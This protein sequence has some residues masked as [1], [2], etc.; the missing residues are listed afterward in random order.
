MNTTKHAVSDYLD[1]LFL[2]VSLK[3]AIETDV[4]SG[5]RIDDAGLYEAKDSVPLGQ[6]VVP[7]MDPFQLTS[8]DYQHASQTYVAYL[9]LIGICRA[10][11][12]GSLQRYCLQQCD[13]L[14]R[15]SLKP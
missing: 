12:A 7:A 3:D 9:L 11:P 10:L 6:R 13:I 8:L 5:T 4:E 2:D 15:Q 1:A 14:L